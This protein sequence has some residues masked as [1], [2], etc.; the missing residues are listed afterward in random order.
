MSD[1]IDMNSK[2]FN[3]FCIEMQHKLDSLHMDSVPN[4]PLPEMSY[5]QGRKYIKIIRGSSVYAFINRENGD[6][7][8]P[9]SW[10]APAKH[11][12]GNINAENALDCCE[13]YSIV[14]LRG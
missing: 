10:K 4:V 13:Q 7:M 14:Y 8:K 5:S 12:R 9:A 6:I 1:K 2:V 3:D 11:A